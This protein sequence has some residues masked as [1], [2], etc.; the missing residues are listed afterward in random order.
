VHDHPTPAEPVVTERAPKIP[1]EGSG[2]AP[3]DGAG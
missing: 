2:A 1:T 3:A